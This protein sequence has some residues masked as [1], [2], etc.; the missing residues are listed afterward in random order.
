M[1]EKDAAGFYRPVGFL[2][3]SVQDATVEYTFQYLR[4][5][6]ERD[7]F[8]AFLGLSDSGRVYRSEGLF[9]L[10]AERIMDPRRPEHPMFL[11]ALDLSDEVTPLEVLAR[12]GGQR[13]GDGIMLLP[14]PEVAS[15]GYTHCTFL[16]HGM[17]FVPGADERAGRLSTGEVL[18]IRLEPGNASNPHALLIVD[19]GGQPLGYVPDAL[20]DYVHAVEGAR[21][22]V[23]RVNGPEVG[24]RLRLLVRLEGRSDPG[25]PPF[26]GSDW[27]TTG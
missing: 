8:R 26:T 22:M 15:D 18:G 6:V 2:G 1:T 24:A 17:R 12:S 3:A 25:A 21:V 19:G 9:P 5:A 11:A 27:A 14:V 23:L 16:V 20:L 10:F 13:A 4:S 7:G